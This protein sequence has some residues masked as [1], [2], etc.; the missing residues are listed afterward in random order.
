[1]NLCESLERLGDEKLDAAMT[2]QV[3]DQLLDSLNSVIG[4]SPTA[5]TWYSKA[6]FSAL[7]QLMSGRVMNEV[8][9]LNAG[10]P[11]EISFDLQ[12]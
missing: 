11:V 2:K 12:S 10:D 1:M 6:S 9:P 5:L 4:N 3:F 7:A 8:G